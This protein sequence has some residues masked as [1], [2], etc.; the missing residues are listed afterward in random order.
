MTI[1]RYTRL[2][3]QAHLSRFHRIHPFYQEEWK[4]AHYVL[5]DLATQICRPWLQKPTVR[6]SRKTQ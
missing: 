4:Q 5:S 6:K 1:H 3:L 2:G